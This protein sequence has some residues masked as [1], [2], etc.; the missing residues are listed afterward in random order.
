MTPKSPLGY[1]E[2]D[3][4]AEK[5]AVNATDTQH[6]FKSL[7]EARKVIEDWRQDY[8]HVRPQSALGQMAPIEALLTK[9]FY[10]NSHSEYS[11]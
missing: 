4:A 2:P 11:G 6:W 8:N 7:N 5:T 9:K 10:P 3:G 1:H